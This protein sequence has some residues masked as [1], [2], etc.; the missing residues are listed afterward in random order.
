[1]DRF[2]FGICGVLFFAMTLLD[3]WTYLSHPTQANIY[4][5]DSQKATKYDKEVFDMMTVEA[6]RAGVVKG[7]KT[8]VFELEQKYT[9]G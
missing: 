2:K 8:T 1:M 4:V 6:D 7:N 3:Y 9:G 5:E